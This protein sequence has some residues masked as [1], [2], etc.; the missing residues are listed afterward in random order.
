MRFEYL[1]NYEKLCLTASVEEIHRVYPRLSKKQIE[2][3]MNLMKAADAEWERA[4]FRRFLRN[5]SW[6]IYR[7]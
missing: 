4:K 3:D 5:L 6:A 2:S 1:T 7:A